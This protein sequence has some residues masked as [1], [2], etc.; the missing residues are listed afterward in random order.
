MSTLEAWDFDDSTVFADGFDDCIVGK[1]YRE[2]K[3]VYSIERILESLMLNQ[4]LSL[5]ESIEYFDFNIGGAYVGDLTP[6]YIWQG[7]SY[8]S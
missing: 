6:L 1:D 2:G 8:T 3:A 7:E 5:E 4:N